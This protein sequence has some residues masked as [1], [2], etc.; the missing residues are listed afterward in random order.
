[1]CARNELQIDPY[2]T[3]DFVLL[4][5]VSFEYVQKRT[6]SAYMPLKIENR[7]VVVV[8]AQLVEQLLPTPEIRGSNPIIGNLICCQLY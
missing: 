5:N 2:R 4:R 3:N 6:R 1:M 8:V 7:A